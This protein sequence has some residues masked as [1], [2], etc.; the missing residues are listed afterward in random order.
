MK[1]IIRHK[2]EEWREPIETET[3]RHVLKMQRLLKSYSPDLVRL[4]GDVEKLPRKESYLF[5]LNL[6]L[7]TGTMYA[8]GEGAEVR[9]SVKTAF[10]ELEAQIKK[11]MAL[12]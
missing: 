6:R 12:L 4:H 3:T 2:N 9:S 8:T 11:H 10:C 7:P 5:S 1:L